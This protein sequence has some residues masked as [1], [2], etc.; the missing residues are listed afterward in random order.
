MF[1]VRG[2]FDLRVTSVTAR[3]ASRASAYV[4]ASDRV[5]W[6]MVG[7]YREKRWLAGGLRT[8]YVPSGPNRFAGFVRRT[9]S[10][11]F[12]YNLRSG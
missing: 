10:G 3:L 1:A 2:C 11:L 8:L 9:A 5:E 12:Q 6:C 4:L 7:V